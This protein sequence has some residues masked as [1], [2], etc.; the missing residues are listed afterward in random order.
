MLQQAS[1]TVAQG[2]DDTPLIFATQTTATVADL[3]IE[4]FN[5]KDPSIPYIG[6]CVVTHTVTGVPQVSQADIQSTVGASASL[7]PVIPH[8]SYIVSS[9]VGPMPLTAP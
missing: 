9:T 3:D 4:E 5:P 7:Q 8:G 2:G 6:S 1:V